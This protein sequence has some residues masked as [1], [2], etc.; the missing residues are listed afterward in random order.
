MKLCHTKSPN[1]LVPTTV[2][3][4]TVVLLAICGCVYSSWV[5]LKITTAAGNESKGNK[6]CCH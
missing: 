1:R 5:M 4:I 2:P 3:P 6:E